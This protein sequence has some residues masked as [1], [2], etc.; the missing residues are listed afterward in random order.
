MNMTIQ[1]WGALG[2]LIGAVAVVASLIYLAIQIRQNTQQI[3][4]S[5]EA[6]KREALERNIESSNRIRELL[7][8]NS[9][10]TDLFLKG[11]GAREELAGSEKFRFAMLMSNTFSAFQGAYLRTL[12]TG[13]DPLEFRGT[14]RLIDSILDNPGARA[15]LESNEPDWRPEFQRFIEERLATIDRRK[16]QATS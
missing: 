7:I 5:V 2:D 15:W 4:R 13:S 14:A 9:E 1:D 6:A 12:T 11:L 16:R 8:L 10:V 3:E